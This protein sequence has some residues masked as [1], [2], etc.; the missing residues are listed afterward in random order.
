MKGSR[1]DFVS[2]V[3]KSCA[4]K[5]LMTAGW[6]GRY[7]SPTRARYISK[8]L[9]LGRGKI[10]C[11]RFFL[12]KTY[13]ALKLKRCSAPGTWPHHAP[14]WDTLPKNKEIA[15]SSRSEE[16][17]HSQHAHTTAYK[18]FPWKEHD[19]RGFFSRCTSNGSSVD[20][21]VSLSNR[22]ASL[23]ICVCSQQGREGAEGT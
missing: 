7:D 23:R 20:I 22:L 6:P 18:I 17:E 15:R 1:A 11:L 10:R 9:A 16:Q 8:E 4:P 19:V 5:T 14:T 21:F 2:K 12:P 13:C 3:P